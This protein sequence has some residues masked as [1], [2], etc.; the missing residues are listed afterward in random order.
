MIWRILLLVAAMMVAGCAS[1]VTDKRDVVVRITSEPPLALVRANGNTYLTPASLL[2]PRGEGAVEINV[3][4]KGYARQTFSLTETEE[5]WIMLNVLSLCTGCVVDLLNGA[6]Y[7]LEPKT[8][9]VIL[10]KD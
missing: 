2:L 7:S 8:I 10:Q 3:E 4:K 9:H 5:P 6:G 1:M